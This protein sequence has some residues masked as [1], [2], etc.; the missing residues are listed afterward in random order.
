[1]CDHSLGMGA[2]GAWGPCMH[3]DKERQ[4]DWG[5]DRWPWT[6][7]SA[8]VY[9]VCFVCFIQMLHMIH[10]NVVY[11]IMAIHVCCKCIFQMF[12]L[13]HL[14]T[15]CFYLDVAYV[16]VAIRVYCNCT[17]HMFHLFQIYVISVLSE[18]Y[19]CCS[20]YTHMLQA[21]IFPIYFTLF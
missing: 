6:S 5:S 14:D 8:P 2:C 9:G 17:F 11:V 7:N 10:L 1:M 16:A 19:I 3:S 18:C 21:Y 15:A 20:N 4:N 12:Q 13:F